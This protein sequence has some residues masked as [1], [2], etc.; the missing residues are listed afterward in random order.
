MPAELPPDVIQRATR[1]DRTA[2][3]DVLRRYVK[4]LHRLVRLSLPTSDVD[5]LTQTLLARLVEVLPRFDPRGPAT[6]STWVF[7]IAHRFVLDE[8]KRFKPTL[9]PVDTLETH[10]HAEA[11]GETTTARTQLRDALERAL[12]TLPD[13]QRRPVVLVHVFD[14][15]LD[16]VA[17]VEGVPVGTIKSRLFRARV[18]LSRALGPEFLED[19][20]HG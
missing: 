6:L 10:A 11:E 5:E 15:S 7:T 18:A 12:A 8:R 19:H 14:H 16:E 20:R 13:E 9:V 17:A 3:G 2:L 4:P 1:G